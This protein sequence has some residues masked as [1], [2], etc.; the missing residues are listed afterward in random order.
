M[1]CQGI[2]CNSCQY[3]IDI[4]ARLPYT[5]ICGK[6]VLIKSNENMVSKIFP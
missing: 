5:S 1:A 3:F 6:Q 4:H 2:L